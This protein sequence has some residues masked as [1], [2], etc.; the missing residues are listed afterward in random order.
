[1][2]MHINWL[3]SIW[4]ELLKKGISEQNIEKDFLEFVIWWK[5]KDGLFPERLKKPIIAQLCI[6]K[7]TMNEA[8]E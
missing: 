4:Y 5:L 1:M 7:I 6:M 3:V 8:T 2:E